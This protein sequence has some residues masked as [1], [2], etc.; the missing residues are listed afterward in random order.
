MHQSWSFS[1]QYVPQEEEFDML[2]PLNK[3]DYIQQ[4]IHVTA[5]YHQQQSLYAKLEVHEDPGP[6]TVCILQIHF[7]TQ[8]VCEESLR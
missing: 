5:Q 6:S 7:G 3:T 1:G 2:W 8:V 4:S